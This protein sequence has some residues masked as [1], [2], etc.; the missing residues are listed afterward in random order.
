[1]QS[2][3][4]VKIVI[5]TTLVILIYAFVK[6]FLLGGLLLSQSDDVDITEIH[7]QRFSR[8]GFV[9]PS[10]FNRTCTSEFLDL[11]A[12]LVKPCA[13]RTDAATSGDLSSSAC[14]RLTCGNLLRGDDPQLYDLAA[15]FTRNFTWT[16]V[17]NEQILN[18]TRD[19]AAF[20]RR[21]GFRD[22][23]DPESAD[24]PIAYN[25]LTHSN[26]N[27]LVRLLRAIYRPH[28]V[29]CIHVD[30]KAAPSFHATVDAIQRCFDNVRLASRMETIVWAGYSRLQADI[31]C[32]N[33]HLEVGGS[34]KYL[35]NTAAL[36]FPL[37]TV[38]ETARILRAYNGANDV[39]GIFGRRVHRGRFENEWLELVD[40]RTLRKTGRLNPKPPHNIDIVR[41]SAYAVF[42]RGFVE[43]ILRDRRARDLLEWSRRTWSPDEFYW[44]TLHHIYANPH[45]HTPGGYPGKCRHQP[46]LPLR[47][48]KQARF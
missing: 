33:D 2:Q 11:P 39:E 21:R 28:N 10:S 48:A 27:Q 13:T 45:L 12:T 37:R 46:Y 23:V 9:F 19:C 40:K 30:T 3:K 43:F 14:S 8:Y 29:V 36:A 20:R 44:S 17:G 18:E 42:S 31:N 5:L 47:K 15:N 34:W 41:G 22:V 38:E 25:I 32:M 24:F 7:I 6:G 4:L 1:M 35:I 26:A 16:P